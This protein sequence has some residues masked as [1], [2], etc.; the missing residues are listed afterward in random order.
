[1]VF[2][3]IPVTNLS[4]SIAFYKAVGFT[5]NTQ[6]SDETAACMVWSDSFSLMIITHEKWKTFTSR[7]IPDAKKSAQFGLICMLDSKTAVDQ[8]VVNGAKA[9]G[10]ADPNPVEDLGFMYGRS[11]EDPDGH[12][13]EP[14][15]MD[16]SAIPQG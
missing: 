9:G 6:F 16:M 1:M 12:I 10:V 15:W 14:K 11:L 2:V 5:Q 4:K 13:W 8:A 3:S 7:T